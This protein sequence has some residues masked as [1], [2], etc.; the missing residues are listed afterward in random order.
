MQTFSD[1][2]N[3]LTGLVKDWWTFSISRV[4]YFGWAV[5]LSRVNYF[6]W[7]V[8]VSRVNYFG[9][10][11]VISGVC[12]FFMCF[13]VIDGLK[14]HVKHE[15]TSLIY[16][17]WMNMN[18]ASALLDDFLDDQKT[19]TDSFAVLIRSTLQFSKASE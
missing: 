16:A 15:E 17:I 9:G 18:W 13:T 11:V 2:T 1:W 12:Y 14:F 4:N 10:A 5:V 7:A 6:G 3:F 19:Q 8:V